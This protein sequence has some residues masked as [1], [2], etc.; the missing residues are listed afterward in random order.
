MDIRIT[1]IL[2]SK[3]VIMNL[4]ISITAIAL[5]L[6]QFTFASEKPTHQP[7]ELNEF[8]RQFSKNSKR[9]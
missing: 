9:S 6:T 8:L 3:E 5:I 1:S 7:K 4:K 2:N